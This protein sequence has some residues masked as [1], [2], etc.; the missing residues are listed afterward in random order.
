METF[1]TV[2]A[3]VLQ[4]SVV[5]G[6][7][8]SSAPWKSASGES[9]H[10]QSGDQLESSSH[11]RCLHTPDPEVRPNPPSPPGGHSSGGGDSSWRGT[12]QRET[13]IGLVCFVQQ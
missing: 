4:R 10:T 6:D 8:A 11:G 7:R 9:E 12:A 2:S 1:S 5:L 13:E 3:G